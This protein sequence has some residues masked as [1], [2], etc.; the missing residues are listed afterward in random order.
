M[1]SSAASQSCDWVICLCAQWCGVCREW[2][3][4]F[5][6]AAADQTGVRFGWIDVEDQAEAMGDVDVETFPTVLVACGGRPMFFGPVL[7]STGQFQ[8]LLESARGP[9]A[10]PAG[11]TPEI[12][13][14]FPRLVS[15]LRN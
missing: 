3:A 8:R 12:A 7:P 6:A 2:R 14:L 15:L 5:E 1:E 9:G 13:E 10:A 4:S 11:V